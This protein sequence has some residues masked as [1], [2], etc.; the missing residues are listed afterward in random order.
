[1]KDILPPLQ[2]NWQDQF[3]IDWQDVDDVH[4]I[5]I[6][7]QRITDL[8]TQARNERIKQ[9]GSEMKQVCPLMH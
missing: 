8:W 4:E 6:V 3:D 5:D 2:E 7:M 1:L 9:A